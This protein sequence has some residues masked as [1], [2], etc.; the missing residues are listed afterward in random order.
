[1][2]VDEW[3]KYQE[4]NAKKIITT[5]TIPLSSIKYI[6]G[7]DISFN[8]ADPSIAC[9]YLTIYDID[10]QKIV[11]EDYKQ[12]KLTLPYVSGFLG[13]REMPVYTELLNKIKSNNPEYYPDVIMVD[14]CGILHQRGFGSASHL[15]YVHDI[16]SIGIGKTLMCIDGLD[17]KLTKKEFQEKCKQK[18]NYIKL[19]GNSGKVYGVALKGAQDTLNPIY[20]SVGHKISLESAVD[21]VTRCCLYRIPEPIRNSDQKSKLYL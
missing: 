5:D 7:V 8:K 1:M 19:I 12:I 11:Y 15:G 20:V 4:E 2:Q 21:L 10:N 6:G 17:E 13:F 18:G 14:G 9:G 16:I 3:S